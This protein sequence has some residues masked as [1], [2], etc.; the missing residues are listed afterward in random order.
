MPTADSTEESKTG[1]IQRHVLTHFSPDAAGP[2]SIEK[3]LERLGKARAQATK[4]S[5]RFLT[6]SILFL[7][8]YFVKLIGLRADLVIF[9][10]KIFEVPYGILIFCMASQ[11]CLCLSTARLADARIYDR[12]LKAVCQ[13]AWPGQ[14]DTMYKLVPDENSWLNATSDSIDALESRPLLSA[15][16][17]FA[18]LPSLLLGLVLFVSP[19][20]AGLYYL[21]DWIEQIKTGNISLQ[22]YSVLASTSVTFL[23]VVLYLCLYFADSD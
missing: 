8:L 15:I 17:N 5:N 10:Q 4:E 18:M 13:N 3:I 11:L 23:W 14:A 19:I 6:L 22:Y 21:Y 12:Y 2:G 1:A 16:Y 9:D 7:G 20:L